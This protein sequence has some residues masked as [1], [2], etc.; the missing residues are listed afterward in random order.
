MQT[1]IYCPST[2]QP[3]R[4]N[5][6]NLLG[7]AGL[8]PPSFLLA[9]PPVPLQRDSKIPDIRLGGEIIAQMSSCLSLHPPIPHLLASV[10]PAMVWTTPC[11]LG[12]LFLLGQVFT[13]K[14]GSCRR[15]S[16]Q[17]CYS[18]AGF[19][20]FFLSPASS[21]RLRGKRSPSESDLEASPW[22][23]TE[24]F[25]KEGKGPRCMDTPLKKWI[26]ISNTT[27][28]DPLNSV[29][30]CNTTFHKM[31]HAHIYTTD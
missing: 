20:K 14:R 24:G 22:S 15:A 30:R 8:P 9:P 31:T 16:S 18:Q 1:I 10:K 13:V 17:G 7:H 23:K 11:S 21:S 28:T 27:P 26:P 25:S 29:P 6:G 2:L 4:P 5:H 19:D 12:G 3:V